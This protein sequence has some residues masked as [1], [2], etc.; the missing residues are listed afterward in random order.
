VETDES[1]VHR[2]AAGERAAL[3]TLFA[4]HRDFVF[5]VA[6]GLAGRREE[7]VDIVQ[8][9]FVALLET[10]PRLRA[11]GGQ[12]TTWLYRVARN[13]ALDGRRKLARAGARR[14]G[15]PFSRGTTSPEDALLAAERHAALLVQLRTLPPRPREVFVLRIGLGLSVE[16]T[17]RLAGC[18]PGAVRR[19]L[20]K[21]GRMLRERLSS[22]R[23][24][25]QEEEREEDE[26]EEEERDGHSPAVVAE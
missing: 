7:A 4:R 24:G 22:A 14:A 15:V 16:Q 19:A 26:E 21:A 6:L 9:V 5:R 11:G 25:R 10:P 8:D 13:R 18:R 20:H 3:A 17:S 2:L 23:E 12:L 1:L